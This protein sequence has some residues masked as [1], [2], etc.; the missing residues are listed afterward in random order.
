MRILSRLSRGK[1]NGS[2]FFENT[3]EAISE[4][5]LG[6][7][8]VRVKRIGDEISPVIAHADRQIMGLFITHRDEI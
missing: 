1:M 5:G 2:V 6:L 4:I 3:H 7:K 8:F